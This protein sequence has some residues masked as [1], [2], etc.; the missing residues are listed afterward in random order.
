[1]MM[2]R[3][4]PKFD[5]IIFGTILGLG[6]LL[7]LTAIQFGLPNLYHADEPIVVNH[8]LAYASGDINP[9][10]FRIPPLTSYL[11]CFLYGIFYLLGNLFH[12]FPDPQTFEF[13]FYQDP[14]LF[15]LLGRFA[16][17]VLP[18]FLTIFSLFRLVNN[19][20]LRSKALLGAFFLSVC[21]LHVKDAHY[22]YP[23]SSLV[24]VMTLSWFPL[25]KLAEKRH[26]LRDHSLAGAFCGLAV[27]LKYN[28]VALIIP[29]LF[30]LA[31]QGHKRPSASLK[32]L[33]FYCLLAMGV[34]AA[35]NPYSI[36]DWH[37]FWNEIKSEALAHQGGTPFLHHLLYSLP[38]GIGWTLLVTSVLG[39]IKAIRERSIRRSA[40]VLFV[41][42]YYLILW[43]SGQDYE[44]YV[45]PMIPCLMV[46]SADFVW[47]FLAIRKWHKPL[48]AILT[49]IILSITNIASSAAWLSI[50][51]KMDTRTQAQIWI[52]SHLKQ[53]SV[54]A[55]DGDF[56]MPRLKFSNKQLEE[57]KNFLLQS[58]GS[59]SQK[60]NRIEYMIKN[61]PP[62]SASYDLYFM[63]RGQNDNQRFIFGRPVISHNLEELK[64]YGV[65][66]VV[67]Q[68]S[69]KD[70]ALASF[71]ADLKK[72]GTELASFTPYKDGKRQEVYDHIMMTGGP[73]DWRELLNRK[74]NGLSLSIYKIKDEVKPNVIQSLVEKSIEET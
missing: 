52:D 26:R 64:K 24:W 17:G 25:W 42:A 12:V 4:M 55:L 56:F 7:R 48:I 65:Q 37:T 70:P 44:R 1:M 18:S 16:L 27:A 46:L 11:L 40:M 22:I 54:I 38:G 33:L 9:H 71:Y 8:A 31:I 73:F 10:F 57:K 59:T 41:I 39:M 34:Y 21:F 23:D 60:L 6:F 13:F 30:V 61:T 43:K 51:L 63:V 2:L 35:L 5:L 69:I 74:S 58:E 3:R 45:L 49:A 66:Y 68:N 15:Y 19:S 50:M 53:N 67:I 28:G 47:D 62:G 36:I 32:G 20:G 72:S 29:Y 14:T